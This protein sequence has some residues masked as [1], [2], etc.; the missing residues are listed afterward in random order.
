MSSHE[1]ILGRIRKAPKGRKTA[2]F[3]DLDRTLV[4]SYTALGLVR[5]QYAA[6]QFG[7][8]DLLQLATVAA[9]ATR[10]TLD[11]E[12]ALRTPFM[13]LAGEPEARFNDIA[14]SAFKK[15]WRDAIYPEALELI[16]AHRRHGHRIVIV[17]SATR[18]QIAPIAAELGISEIICTELA[19]E[20]G[21]FTGELVGPPCWGEHKLVAAQRYGERHRIALEDCYFY[22]D[23]FEDLPLLEKVG[24]PCALNPDRKLEQ[25]CRTQQWPWCRFTSRQQPRA[26]DV[27]RTALAWGAFVPALAM[28]AFSWLRN[29]SLKASASRSFQMWSELGLLAAGVELNVKGRQHLW[30]HR[31]AIFVFN[32]Q[33]MLD[34][35][36]LPAL[37]QGQF[38]VM[39]KKEAGDVPI[40][41]KT[42]AAAGFILFDR[43]DPQKAREACARAAEQIRA[44]SSLLIAPEGTRSYSNKLLPF[45]KGAFHVALETR[46]PI[47]PIVLRN[48]SE[49][50][51]RSSQFMRSGTLDVEV[52]P[53]IATTH[54]KVET[55]QEHVDAI[56][57]LFL[58]RLGQ[59]SIAS[60]AENEHEL[61]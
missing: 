44:G 6:K 48:T 23:A 60:P 35:F 53:P 45:K 29:R 21:L 41:G 25:H 52:L 13:M 56:R 50:W 16:A 4:A 18:Y 8:L 30:T 9:F 31:P 54:W 22:T 43:S 24:Y 15:H 3:F 47:V 20:D 55:L 37:L 57:Q 58:E 38:T 11:F 10:G 5:E 19:V 17:S 33:S 40:I 46:V 12:Q 39:G 14:Q 51:P 61:T 49:L 28:G 26:Q 27:L 42:V 34:G 2:A 59:Q 7:A 1:E 32:H 36:A